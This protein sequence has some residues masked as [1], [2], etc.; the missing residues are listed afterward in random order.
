MSRTNQIMKFVI[1]AAMAMTLA[2]V[3]SGAYAE[4]RL[5]TE[6]NYKKEA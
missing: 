1:N 4:E 3:L 5:V 2:M 6:P